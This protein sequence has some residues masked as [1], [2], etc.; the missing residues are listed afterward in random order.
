[1]SFYDYGIINTEL[2]K[3]TIAKNISTTV[4]RIPLINQSINQSIYNASQYKS[5]SYNVTFAKWTITDHI[6]A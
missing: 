3:A 5:M 6:V 4:A 1:M 2:K